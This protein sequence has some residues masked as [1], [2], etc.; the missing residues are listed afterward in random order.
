MRNRLTNARI[1]SPIVS[2]PRQC[3]S[4]RLVHS[5]IA[6]LVAPVCVNFSV[7]FHMRRS[8]LYERA[9]PGNGRKGPFAAPQQQPFRAYFSLCS[10]ALQ[11]DSEAALRR[12]SASFPFARATGAGEI[13]RLTFRPATIPPAQAVP[14][15]GSAP[16]NPSCGSPGP[17]S[18]GTRRRG[19][20]T[21]P[22]RCDRES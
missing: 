14:A 7:I 10:S 12:L 19:P 3:I 1:A 6:L 11:E 2:S 4:T 18:R 15:A 22:V 21:A 17:N 13:G 20:W 5:G 8:H 9:D 16:C